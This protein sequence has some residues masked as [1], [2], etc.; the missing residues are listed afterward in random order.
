MLIA[1]LAVVSETATL[2]SAVPHLPLSDVPH[3]IC[4]SYRSVYRSYRRAAGDQ[5]AARIPDWTIH[6]GGRSEGSSEKSWDA[7]YGRTADRDRHCGAYAAVG[8]LEQ[9]LRVGRGFCHVR[10]RGD[11][12]R[13][14]ITESL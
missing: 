3:C 6:S 13:G 5:P 9:S 8:G 10:V 4:Q 14:R 1:L 12:I 2:F 7:D 11:W